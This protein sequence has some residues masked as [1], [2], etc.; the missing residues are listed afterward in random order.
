M[1]N[2][3][4]ILLDLAR[5]KSVSPEKF[6]ALVSAHDL[7]VK[8][9]AEAAFNK[10]FHA[11]AP[12]LPIIHENGEITYRDG[13]TGTYATNDAIQ[14]AIQ[15]IL[16]KHGFTLAF[17]TTYPGSE[18]NVDGILTHKKGH[19]RRSSFTSGTDTSG[20][21]T[22]AQGRGSIISYGHR[23]TSVDLL[24]LIT[25]GADD[26]AQSDRSTAKIS[27]GLL[28]QFP[29][30]C[31]AAPCGSVALQAEW[32]AI[33]EDGRMLVDAADWDVLKRMA[34]LRDEAG[35]ATR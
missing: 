2:L 26:D 21:K 14:T 15:P 18:I 8:Q 30:L 5:D 27:A 24:N 34:A 9:D 22:T 29:G 17:E 35:D 12:D 16:W 20:G 1:A 4:K 31:K 6:Q 33:G 13:R 7:K 23:Y 3:P 11:M 32:N 19:A 28:I 25:R 10:A